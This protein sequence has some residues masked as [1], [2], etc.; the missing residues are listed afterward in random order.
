[1][2]SWIGVNTKL[3]GMGSRQSQ[4]YWQDPVILPLAHWIAPEKS[5]S[6]AQIVGARPVP[7]SQ[8][9]R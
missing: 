1:M 8:Q 3:K 5:S 2:V 9:P 7:R 6:A 4:D